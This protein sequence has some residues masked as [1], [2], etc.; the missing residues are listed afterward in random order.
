M[1]ARRQWFYM[2]VLLILL[3]GCVVVIFV[4][5]GIGHVWQM[6]VLGGG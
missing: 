5:E 4:L 3:L 1:D 2:A 6:M